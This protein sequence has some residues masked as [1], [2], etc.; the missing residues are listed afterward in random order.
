LRGLYRRSSDRSELASEPLGGKNEVL[1]IGSNLLVQ[2][3]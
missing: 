1:S 3:A 2:A